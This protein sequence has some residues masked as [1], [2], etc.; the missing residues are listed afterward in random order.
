[1]AVR[2]STALDER[3]SGPPPTR[4]GIQH[5]EDQTRLQPLRSCWFCLERA[6][7]AVFELREAQT[8]AK[9]IQ[10]Y[11]FEIEIGETLRYVIYILRDTPSR[12]A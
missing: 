6:Y 10:M 3:T 2:G 4:R 11:A 5:S 9:G 12:L 7:I 1:M 8:V